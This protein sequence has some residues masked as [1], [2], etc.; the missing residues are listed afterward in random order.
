[1]DDVRLALRPAF[2]SPY[3]SDDDILNANE[4]RVREKLATK[5]GDMVQKT[6]SQTLFGI[7]TGIDLNGKLTTTRR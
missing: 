1:M 5:R 3:M 2:E 6:A 7:A 4:K